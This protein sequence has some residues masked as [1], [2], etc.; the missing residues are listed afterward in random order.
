MLPNRSI[1]V[2]SFLPDGTSAL[3]SRVQPGPL[4]A[5]ILADGSDTGGPH[6][7]AFD[8]GP[9]RCDRDPRRPVA[10]RSISPARRGRTTNRGGRYPQLGSELKEGRARPSSIA[11]PPPPTLPTVPGVAS[12]PRP[13]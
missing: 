2:A 8:E 6:R 1:H 4:T 12:V 10:G 7:E 9:S 11:L 5:L 13:V 3:P